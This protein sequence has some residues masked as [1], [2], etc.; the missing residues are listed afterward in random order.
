M[1]AAEL[2][3]SLQVPGAARSAVRAAGAAPRLV[4]APPQV[5]GPRRGPLVQEARGARPL[6]PGGVEE[7][8]ITGRGLV[9]HLQQ[10]SRGKSALLQVYKLPVR[11][12][13]LLVL[14]RKN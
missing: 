14:K 1:F 5:P 9:S 11:S 3:P 2:T 13:L 6:D 7:L 10:V 4:H 8:L 12:H